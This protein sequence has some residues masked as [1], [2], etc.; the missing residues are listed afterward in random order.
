MIDSTPSLV[1]VYE[2]FEF[3]STYNLTEKPFKQSTL[4]TGL[5][6]FVIRSELEAPVSD[7][8]CNWGATGLAG[9]PFTEISSILLAP[10]APILPPQH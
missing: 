4:K 7:P 3:P 5:L 1:Q 10:E 6:I 9:V 2:A 8:A